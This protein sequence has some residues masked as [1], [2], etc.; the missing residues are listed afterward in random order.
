MRTG[1]QPWSTMGPS[2][3]VSGSDDPG[4][5]A[6]RASICPSVGHMLTLP[7]RLVKP[8]QVRGSFYDWFGR[9]RGSTVFRH[10]RHACRRK[11]AARSQRDV[12]A[13]SGD[14]AAGRTRAREHSGERFIPGELRGASHGS[15]GDRR[16]RGG[17][18]RRCSGSADAH[19]RLQ[20]ALPF[21]TQRRRSWLCTMPPSLAACR[22]P[23][24]SPRE[25]EQPPAR[26]LRD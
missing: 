13:C 5:A 20:P 16:H 2:G 6:R 9:R 12:D 8:I 18:D 4:P 3:S 11:D 22:R 17:A 7:P 25:H 21:R 15:L 26:L 19:C 23:R 10:R 1:I 14:C 24:Q